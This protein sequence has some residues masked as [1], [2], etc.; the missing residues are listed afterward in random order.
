MGECV[1]ALEVPARTGTPR[2][3]RTINRLNILGPS[4]VSR[5]ITI[6]PTTTVH[7]IVPSG[8]GV[9]VILSPRLTEA[10]RVPCRHP[11]QLR[12]RTAAGAATDHA[13]TGRRIAPRTSGTAAAST[14]PYSS[15]NA[16]RGTPET[17][18]RYVSSTLT[19]HTASGHVAPVVRNGVSQRRYQ[20]YTAGAARNTVASGHA[21]AA[22]ESTAQ[23]CRSLAATATPARAAS[24]V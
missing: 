12:P 6:L 24:A 19:V 21:Q 16:H 13:S 17:K 14:R 11:G 4:S 23:T 3:T 20:G 10:A 22:G 18:S 1:C 7:R 5:R 9:Q 15:A 2:R 8:A